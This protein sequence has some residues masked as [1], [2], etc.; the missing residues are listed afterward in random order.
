MSLASQGPTIYWH[1]HSNASYP[2]H[3]I[4]YIMG[5][6]S[7]ISVSHNMNKLMMGVTQW[8]GFRLY[9]VLDSVLLLVT[10]DLQRVT[11]SKISGCA[12]CYSSSELLFLLLVDIFATWA[13]PYK[14]HLSIGIVTA[15]WVILYIRFGHHGCINGIS[16][17]HRVIMNKLWWR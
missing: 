15:M 16:V 4:F 9:I 3:A 5:C 2:L 12:N 14:D 6:I 8:G 10:T 13:S 1:C 17:S 7:N 11:L